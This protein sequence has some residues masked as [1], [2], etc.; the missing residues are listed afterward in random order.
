MASEL[1]GNYGLIWDYL[2]TNSGDIS[3]LNGSTQGLLKTCNG[4]GILSGLFGGAYLSDLGVLVDSVG[5][6]DSFASIVPLIGG[7]VCSMENVADY[8]FREYVSDPKFLSGVA[9]GLLFEAGMIATCTGVGAP[10]GLALMGVGTVCTAY[11]SGLL[12]FNSNGPY[13]NASQENCLD[14]GFSMSLNL[15]TGGSSGVAARS[16]FKEV[17]GKVSQVSIRNVVTTA[18]QR[19]IYSTTLYNTQKRVVTKDSSQSA[20]KYI[21]GELV[22]SANPTKTDYLHKIA[23]EYEEN[24][25]TNYLFDKIKYNLLSI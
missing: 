20:G 21:I 5:L 6:E 24:L 8:V 17:G 15:I 3:V 23:E 11:S 2:T 13:I 7:V 9:G 4:M 22:D 19:G 14:F 18:D 1:L 25:V 12:D 16:A 10:I